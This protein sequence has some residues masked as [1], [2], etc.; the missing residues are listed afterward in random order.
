MNSGRNI[1]NTNKIKVKANEHLA[2]TKY[3][4]PAFS[5]DV[6]TIGQYKI[7]TIYMCVCLSE[8]NET[9]IEVYNHI[10]IY[11]HM[12]ILLQSGSLTE[13]LYLLINHLK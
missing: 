9:H 12:H 11:I 10:H 2:N 6:M 4:G 3:I 13:T 8:Y 5:S 1:T 7:S